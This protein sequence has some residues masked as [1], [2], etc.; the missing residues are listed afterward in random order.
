MKNQFNKNK[1][2]QQI[3][4]TLHSIDG[5]QRATPSPFLVTRINARMQQSTAEQNSI[6][7]KLGILLS[8]PS[9][10]FATLLVLL[11]INTVVINIAGNY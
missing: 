10:A 3:E 4:E 2:E 11:L 1:I 8:R 5:L 9:I 7:Y 6:W